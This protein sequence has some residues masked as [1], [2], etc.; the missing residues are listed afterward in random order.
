MSGLKKTVSTKGNFDALCGCIKF[1][2]RALGHSG[3]HIPL[4]CTVSMQEPRACAGA[5]P[6]A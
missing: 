4:D 2:L 6:Q 1:S 5:K 3:N